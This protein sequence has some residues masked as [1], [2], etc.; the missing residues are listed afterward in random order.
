MPDVAARRGS[1]A[2]AEA[3][4]RY[5]NDAVSREGV[6][7]Y[8]DGPVEEYLQDFRVAFAVRRIPHGARVLDV[9]C[10]AGRISYN[11]GIRR[12]DTRVTG[13]DVSEASLR[14]AAVQ[15]HECSNVVYVQGTLA[16]LP[17]GQ[18]FDSCLLFEVLEHVADPGALLGTI[19]SRLT[20]GGCLLLS[21]PNWCSLGR[22][23]IDPV[24]LNLLRLAGKVRHPS[25]E[26]RPWRDGYSSEHVKEY[27]WFWVAGALG[28]AGFR[29]A[30]TTGLA[31]HNRGLGPFLGRPRLLR[32][33]LNSGR[34]CPPLAHH[35][36]FHAVASHEGREATNPGDRNW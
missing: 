30:Y 15:G 27:T 4:E 6:A 24:W 2:D 28:S 31:L 22:A 23:V 36:Y 25:R 18:K 32:L 17:E 19:R 5:Y 9:G 7:A 35:M 11:V 10:G 29:I 3:Q 26:W 21:T 1:G 16:D 14:L 33:L 12:P 13:L 8:Y 20:P 34:I